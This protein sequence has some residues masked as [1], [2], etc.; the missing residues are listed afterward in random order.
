MDER[1][2]VYWEL[3]AKCLAALQLLIFQHWAKGCK[4]VKCKV[5][6]AGT[7]R[8]YACAMISVQSNKAFWFCWYTRSEVKVCA[9]QQQA[10]IKRN[11]LH[12]YSVHS[13]LKLRKDLTVSTGTNS[14]SHHLE[15]QPRATKLM[16]I[17]RVQLNKLSATFPGLE[18]R[19]KGSP[20]A[21]S[22]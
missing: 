11:G 19:G 1:F 6:D 21:W 17:W 22:L 8:E 2:V 3:C 10:C 7:K 18:G 16:Q 13:I 15:A 20:Q 12:C 4:L 5:L 14:E 9:G